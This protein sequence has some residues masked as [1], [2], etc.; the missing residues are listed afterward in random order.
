MRKLALLASLFVSSI[1]FADTS[2][3]RPNLDDPEIRK[4]I[5]EQAVELIGLEAANET[6]Q[7]C[8]RRH[9]ALHR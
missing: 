9:E 1:C 5:I 8:E 3:E 6:I 2:S 4:K 7:I